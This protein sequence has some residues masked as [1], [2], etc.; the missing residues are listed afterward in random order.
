MNTGIRMGEIGAMT[1]QPIGGPTWEPNMAETP[2]S[3][4]R[5][6]KFSKKQGLTTGLQGLPMQFAGATN[7]LDQ[8]AKVRRQR[9][10]ADEEG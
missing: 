4:R 6:G 3:K 5:G 7:P 9:Y 8:F 1:G 10:G 2:T